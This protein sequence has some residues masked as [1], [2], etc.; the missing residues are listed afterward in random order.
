MKYTRNLTTAAL[1]VPVLWSMDSLAEAP[2]F[3]PEEGTSCS[4]RI[5]RT[6]E[7]A[8]TE[9]SLM[10][11]GTD[12][13]DTF[14]MDME[15]TFVAVTAVTDRYI[16]VGD[17]RPSKFTR[18]FDELSSESSISASGP[19]GDVNADIS[20]SSELEELTV[21]F[22]W[23]DDEEGYDVEFHEDSAGDDGLLVGLNADLD[24]FSL[25]PDDDVS[26]GD[27]WDVDANAMIAIFAPS[28]SVKIKPDDAPNMEMGQAPPDPG[29]GLEEF[30]GDVT[31]TFE[32]VRDVDGTRV[33]V[34]SLSIDVSSA[35]DQTEL[36]Q[37]TMDG[38]GLPEGLAFE[39]ESSDM[40]FL[41]DGGG[42]LLWDLERGIIYSLELS[43]D[44]TQIVDTTMSIAMPGNEQTIETSRTFE[45]SQTISFTTGE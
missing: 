33:A 23:D 20:G 14:E 8:Q 25:L 41:F 22:T 11:D 30:E 32:G 17:G 10:V 6:L 42:E 18:T 45:G 3:G 5:E 1:L 26:E 9:T 28:G 34:I 43:G 31:A 36:V 2:S 29:A 40:E 27:S 21:V 4:K 7:L 24:L 37:N 39:I 38:G 44:V 15:T 12:M 13:S 16:S 35:V 19:M